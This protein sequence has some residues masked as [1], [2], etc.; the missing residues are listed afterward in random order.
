MSLFA[1]YKAEREGITVLE[2]DGGFATF[3][4]LDTRIYLQD[5]FVSKDKRRDGIATALTDQVV[6][7][8]I[9]RGCR[10]LLGTIDVR[11]AGATESMQA[12]LNYGMRLLKVDGNV[13]WLEKDI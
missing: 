5:I 7:I 12:S 11:A 4:V 10:I 6:A 1:E 8:G 2:T 9:S 13:I 3:K